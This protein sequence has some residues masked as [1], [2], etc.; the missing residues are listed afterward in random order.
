MSR[1]A[2]VVGVVG[3]GLVLAGCGNVMPSL[4]FKGAFS[5]APT[6]GTLDV[7]S[8]PPGAEARA[9]TGP[10]CKTPCSLEVPGTG[11]FTVSFA[12]TGYKPQTIPVKAVAGESSAFSTAPAAVRYEPNPVL[13]LMESTAPPKSKRKGRPAKT[14][15]TAK[16]EAAGAPAMQ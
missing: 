8:E 14:S 11:E 10:T 15:A 12:L 5:S 2:R 7:Q 13:A 16:P 4:D 1:V 9:S 3:F 6:G